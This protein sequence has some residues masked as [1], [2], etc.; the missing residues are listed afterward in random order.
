MPKEMVNADVLDLQQFL[1]QYCGQARL[2]FAVGWLTLVQSFISRMKRDPSDY[3]VN[4]NV[5]VYHCLEAFDRETAEVDKEET[6]EQFYIGLHDML[7]MIDD[8]LIRFRDTQPD[9]P[10]W[11]IWASR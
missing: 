4:L 8:M 6:P 10:R 9:D 1:W 5:F 3:R 2:Y 7:L 11:C